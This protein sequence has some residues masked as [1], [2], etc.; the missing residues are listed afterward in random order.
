MR[1]S[2]RPQTLQNIGC[3]ALTFQWQKQYLISNIHT[4][5]DCEAKV[6]GEVKGEHE[7]HYPEGDFPFKAVLLKCP[8]CRE[9]L[10]GGSY[11][12]QIKIGA[13]IET[14]KMLLKK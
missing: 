3:T 2:T 12:Y 11:L 6:D 10:L 5:G 7:T 13:F 9:G 4:I 14:K 1:S 8:V